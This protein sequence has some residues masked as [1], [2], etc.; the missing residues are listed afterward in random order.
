MQKVR[1]SGLKARSVRAMMKLGVGSFTGHGMKLVR[2]MVLARILAPAEIGT[3]TIVLGFSLAFEAFTEV[4]IKEAV[5]QSKHGAQD[6]YLNAAW[7]MQV[8]RGICL[9][10][11]SFFCAPLI[12][13]L[14]HK[15]E[16]LSLLRVCFIAILFRGLVCPRAFVLEKNYKFG[17]SVLLTQGSGFLGAV[18]TICLA[19]I[20]RNVWALVIG[21][22]A[23]MAILSV[24][25]FIMVPFLPRFSFNRERLHELL[26]FSRRIFGLPILAFVSLNVPVLVLGKVVSEDTLGLYGYSLLLAQF[27]I[28]LY[29]KIISPVLLPAFSKKQDDK[30]AL[31]RGVIKVIHWINNFYLLLVVFMICC[32]SEILYYVYGAQ[33]AAMAVPFA[34]LCLNIIF[35]IETSIFAGMYIA[36]GYPHKY[37]HF[38]LLR[39]L[40]IIVLIYPVS[41][42][43]GPVG[44]ALIMVTSNLGV[45]LLQ[46]W[47]SKK[48]IGLTFIRYI[49]SHI[50][51]LLLSIPIIFV[52][53]LLW[54]F[55]VNS[56]IYVVSI[57]TTTFITM[58]GVSAL[59]LYIFPSS[60][61][62][63]NIITAIRN[64]GQTTLIASENVTNVNS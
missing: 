56:S 27:P 8:I 39:A 54:L 60:S 19:F 1:G 33:Y 2:Q 53:D 20:I 47:G 23:E 18:I 51:A 31:R 55:K 57:G 22:V 61:F 5:I 32:S 29:T 46:V 17:R 16:L 40:I 36:L 64:R 34:I 26:T 38:T 3:M 11:I 7:W 37:R 41:F 48:I 9:F 35:R 50:P 28:L 6:D 21:F 52:F 25:S 62:G 63:R 44:V 14:Y 49:H 10:L 42:Y 43:Y 12:S 58:F 24:F 15:P 4:G 45:L 30:E 59:I 13:S